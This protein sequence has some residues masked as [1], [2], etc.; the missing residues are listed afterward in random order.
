MR[1]TLDNTSKQRKVK[2]IFKKTFILQKSDI[3]QNQSITNPMLKTIRIFALITLSSV[4]LVGCGGGD[5]A[6]KESDNKDS[7]Q[8][9]QPKKEEAE[10]K[11]ETKAPEVSEDALRTFLHSKE[12]TYGWQT[13]ANELSLDFFKD[14]RLAVEGP[15][16]EAT[17][18]VGKWSLKGDQL[19]M[20][21]ENCG[22]MK[23][24]ETVTV[25][26][27]GENLVLGEKTYTRYAPK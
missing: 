18:W 11:A 10:P 21:C 5:S 1:L 2:Q 9:E 16:G 17:M 13:K 24:K 20:E 15:D 7:A 26:I 27:D 25:K 19:T 23:S 6:S 12:G 8:T 22:S 14:G 4:L 3:I